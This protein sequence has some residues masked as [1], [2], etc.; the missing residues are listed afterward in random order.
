MAYFPKF[1]YNEDNNTCEEFIYGGCGRD[2]NI[3]DT[4]DEC[5]QR[6]K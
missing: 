5:E 6:C 1:E 2:T 4:L 3:F